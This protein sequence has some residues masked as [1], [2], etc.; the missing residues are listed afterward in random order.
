MNPKKRKSPMH[1][2]ER[3]PVLVTKSNE[4][5]ARKS[6]CRSAQRKPRSNGSQLCFDPGCSSARIRWRW[7][8]LFPDSFDRS[9]VID[10]CPPLKRKE[11]NTEIALQSIQRNTEGTSTQPPVTSPTDELSETIIPNEEKQTNEAATTPTLSTNLDFPAIE[12]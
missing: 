1:S 4:N 12:E 9:P 2:P 5:R 8:F 3:V 10:L 6:H 11:S 7:A